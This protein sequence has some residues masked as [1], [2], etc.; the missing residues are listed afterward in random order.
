[1]SD[2]L[3]G[4]IKINRRWGFI[5]KSKNSIQLRAQLA[6]LSAVGIKKDIKLLIKLVL[7]MLHINLK[8]D[9]ASL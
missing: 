6:A 3:I 8:N 2:C 4:F 9:L 7:E 5:E 1:M